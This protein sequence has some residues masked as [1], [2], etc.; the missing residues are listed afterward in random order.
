[1]SEK[2][3]VYSI[4][5][6][7]L[8]RP[9]CPD[10]RNRIDGATSVSLDETEPTVKPGDL[11]ICCY[12][13]SLNIYTAELRFR[14]ATPSELAAIELNPAKAALFRTL[15]KYSAEWRKTHRKEN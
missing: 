8:H 4:K 10:C 6:R 9:F 7:L 3:H 5:N 13:G 2:L 15:Q 1:M 11:A 12:C 14:K